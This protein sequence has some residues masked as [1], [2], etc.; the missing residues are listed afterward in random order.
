MSAKDILYYEV[1]DIP[2]P[3]L[4][5]LK[6]LKVAF[7]HATKDEISPNGKII[8]TADRDFRIRVTVF[9]KKPLDGAHEIYKFCLGHTEDYMPVSSVEVEADSLELYEEPIT[10]TTSIAIACDDSCVRIYSISDSDRF[11]YHKSL[12]RGM[13]IRC[14]DP[15]SYHKVYRITVGLYLH[16]GHSYHKGDVSALAASLS[17]TR[18]FSAGCDG[19][20]GHETS[21][22]AAKKWSTL[23]ID[24][25]TDVL[26]EDKVKRARGRKKPL[27][28]SYNKWAYM[29]VPMLLWQICFLPGL[30]VQSGLSTGVRLWDH[31]SGL[32]LHTCE[33]GSQILRSPRIR[34]QA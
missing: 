11:T 4:Q 1:L 5:G 6:T 28:F 34:M 13:F 12:P 29:D 21:S 2:L 17:D 14:W 3:E 24:L 18:V 15:I 23:A 26:P 8:V 27:D 16:E 31:T 32:L 30:C 7:H 33:V 10:K 22:N 9:P 20:A 19:S 25:P